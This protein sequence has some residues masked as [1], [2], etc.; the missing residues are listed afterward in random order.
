MSRN[1]VSRQWVLLAPVLDGK[2]GE[3]SALKH[4]FEIVGYDASARAAAVF[5]ADGQLTL[6]RSSAAPCS[7][8]A[9]T[10]TPPGG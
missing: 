10:S 5:V 8:L 2:A 3:L 7:V 1:S 9:M 4:I 6:N